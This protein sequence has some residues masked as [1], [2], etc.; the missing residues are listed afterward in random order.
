MT[1]VSFRLF[2]SARHDLARAVG[3][4]AGVSTVNKIWSEGVNL[5]WSE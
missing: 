1:R 3:A 5:E 4:Y 2:W